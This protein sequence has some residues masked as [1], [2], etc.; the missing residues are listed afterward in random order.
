MKDMMWLDPPKDDSVSSAVELLRN[1]GALDE[2]GRVTAE[3]VR[4]ARQGSD[5][6][7]LLL[8][9]KFLN[10]GSKLQNKH[11]TSKINIQ[12]LI[13]VRVDIYNYSHSNPLGWVFTPDLA[14]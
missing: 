10:I 8:H 11:P 3:G 2:E 7:G 6:A 5:C 9:Y 13:E 14:T 1:L 4:M 12:I